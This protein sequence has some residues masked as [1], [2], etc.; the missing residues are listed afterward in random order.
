MYRELC[1]I[2]L[3]VAD[4][5]WQEIDLPCTS[6]DNLWFAQVWKVWATSAFVRKFVS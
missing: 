4:L 1:L 3:S 5:R 2:Y 6:K